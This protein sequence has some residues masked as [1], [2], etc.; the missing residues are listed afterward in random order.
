MSTATYASSGTVA[1]PAL[2]YGG[3]PGAKARAVSV[4]VLASTGV[5][6]AVGALLP[7]VPGLA[8]FASGL[9]IAGALMIKR[10]EP[11]GVRLLY[12]ASPLTVADKQDLARAGIAP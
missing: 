7:P 6:C 1:L 10:L 8:L 5:T 4:P 12:G 11:L 2:K 9:V 3:L